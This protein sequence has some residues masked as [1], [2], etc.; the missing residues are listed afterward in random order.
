MKKTEVWH[1]DP[2][3]DKAFTDLKTHMCKAPVLM[4]PDFTRKFYVQTDASGYGMGAILL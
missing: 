2:P 1:W 4:Q 3:Q